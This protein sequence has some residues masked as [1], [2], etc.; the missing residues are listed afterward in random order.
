[1]VNVV[2][3]EVAE[4]VPVAGGV[5]AH[6]IWGTQGKDANPGPPR[7]KHAC[8][9]ESIA[10]VISFPTETYNRPSSQGTE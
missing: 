10:A 7:I 3:G 1:M 2:G 4:E 9:D 8:Y 5:C 6:V